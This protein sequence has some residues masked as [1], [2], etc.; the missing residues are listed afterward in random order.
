[1]MVGEAAVVVT[2]ATNPA[3]GHHY[4]LVTGAISAEN[5]QGGISWSEAHAFA[6]DFASGGNTAHL[7]TIGSPEEKEWLFETFPDP[8]FDLQSSFS[9]FWMGLSDRETEGSFSWVNGDP[10]TYT[11][12]TGGGLP[13][14]LTGEE[15]FVFLTNTSVFEPL[16]MR[17]E[18]NDHAD[19]R[20]FSGAFPFSAIIEVEPIPEPA[21]GWFLVLGLT[22]FG[23]RQRP[24]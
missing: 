16:T 15:D 2:S 1:M 18:W 20:L 23:R 9:F 7:V 22:L 11:N 6:D 13:P 8:G 10:L 19:A 21:A 24:G 14:D 3:N 5:P 4:H 17:G 12:W